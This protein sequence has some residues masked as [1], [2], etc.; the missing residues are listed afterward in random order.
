MAFVNEY[1]SDEDVEK[2][3]L[4]EI[5]DKYHPLRRGDYFYGRKPEWTV[6]REAN[7]FLIVLGI[8]HG[9]EGNRID[10]LLWQ[11]GI[12]VKAHLELLDDSSGDLNAVP[13]R[14]VWGLTKL[15]FSDC[16][17]IPKSDITETLRQALTTYGYRGVRKQQP[18]TIVEFRF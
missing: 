5:W 12:E 11:D 10:F 3:G 9:E 15:S 4:K 7:A 1:A 18:K 13:F 6:N 14:R 17:K 16:S 2:Y 8:G